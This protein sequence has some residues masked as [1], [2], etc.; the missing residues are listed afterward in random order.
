[1]YSERV[2]MR[3]IARTL[4][5]DRSTIENWRDGGAK[6]VL[7]GM[8]LVHRALGT[9]RKNHLWL[10]L[11]VANNGHLLERWI[12][13]PT[14]VRGGKDV[15]DLLSQLKGLPTMHERAEQLQVPPG[16][17]NPMNML[18]FLLGVMLGD[19][20]KQHS[21]HA[22]VAHSHRLPSSGL[23]LGLTTRFEY[24]I[25]FGEYTSLCCNSLGLGMIRI[26]DTPPDP[27]RRRS[28]WGSYCWRSEISPLIAWIFS[29]CLGLE[30]R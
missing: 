13:V 15:K 19:A 10:P 29:N 8:Y 2:G 11:K 22:K 12:Q 20:G 1:M 27:L 23:T 4:K 16:E 18:G 17:L 28:K 5:V 3:E 26:V 21:V 6:P 25:R 30:L 14:Q 7:M 9:P 24:N